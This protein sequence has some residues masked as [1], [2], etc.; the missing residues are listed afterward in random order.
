LAAKKKV[1]NVSATMYCYNEMTQNLHKL[2]SKVIFFSHSY[3][4]IV[5]MQC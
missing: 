5:K 1:V 3:I 2:D 4:V